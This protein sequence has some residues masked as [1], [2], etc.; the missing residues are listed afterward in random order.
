MLRILLCHGNQ[1]L[2]VFDGTQGAV[3]GGEPVFDGIVEDFAKGRRIIVTRGPDV[4]MRAL[5]GS[6]HGVIL[7]SG[8]SKWR[9]ER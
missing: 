1:M 8:M 3:E 7:A 5:F 2:L 4:Q 9:L 6:G